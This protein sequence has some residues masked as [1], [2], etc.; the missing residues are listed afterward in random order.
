MRFYLSSFLSILSWSFY[1]L[2]VLVAEE[3]N[4]VALAMVAH[5]LAC[6]AWTLVF[7]AMDR[8]SPFSAMRDPGVIGPI[9]AAAFF[10]V[11]ETACFFVAIL[12]LAPVAATITLELWVVFLVLIGLVFG[13]E[14]VSFLD[15]MLILACF[16]GAGL[17]SAT[18]STDGLTTYDTLISG[19]LGAFAGLALAA[20]SAIHAHVAKKLTRP[21]TDVTRALNPHILSTLIS[22]PL[23]A[24]VVW[25]LAEFDILTGAVSIEAAIPIAICMAIGAPTFIYALIHKPGEGALAIYYCTPVLAVFLLATVGV[26]EVTYF[27]AL[28]GLL[29]ICSNIYLALRADQFSAWAITSLSAP[30]F[31]FLT[32]SLPP[33]LLDLS[34]DN[35]GLGVDLF[36][37]FYGALFLVFVSR[38]FERQSSVSSFLRSMALR[39]D[40]D[41]STDPETK[42]AIIEAIL[43]IFRETLS[44]NHTRNDEARARLIALIGESEHRRDTFLTPVFDHI[45]QRLARNEPVAFLIFQIANIGFLIGLAATIAGTD[46]IISFS[47][48][49]LMCC[50]VSFFSLYCSDFHLRK[51]YFPKAVERLLE[52]EQVVDAVE[53]N[54][55]KGIFVAA[56]VL[57]VATYLYFGTTV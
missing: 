49:L 55:A 27:L 14:K 9:L 30:I 39:A 3:T 51:E 4:A 11:V 54:V 23:Y 32:L 15:F 13:K 47:F 8:S 48:G 33:D 34:G 7:M 21:K 35:A 25:G 53:A 36:I 19:T 57:S 50:I 1:P 10:N 46:R 40:L 28:G 44:F 18:E 31:T 56:V 5:A 37:F 43:D 26:Q 42:R 41:T 45:S 20:K 38:Y 52:G 6:I 2:A 22:L 24:L 16:I 29:V 17:A 12:F